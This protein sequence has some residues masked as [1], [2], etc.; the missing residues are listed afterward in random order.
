LEDDYKI[1]NNE[2]L[3]NQLL[4]FPQILNFSSGDKT[5]PGYVPQPEVEQS[6]SQLVYCSGSI[7]YRFLLLKE[8][9]LK[10]YAIF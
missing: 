3:S 2:H 10:G 6:S 4:Y 8:V 9:K 7:D 5:R 1:S